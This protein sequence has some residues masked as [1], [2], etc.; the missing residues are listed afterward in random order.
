MFETKY[1]GYARLPDANDVKIIKSKGYKVAVLNTGTLPAEIENN[2][3]F[4]IVCIPKFKI[5]RRDTCYLKSLKHGYFSI[6]NN[7]LTCNSTK[8]RFIITTF[9]DGSSQI[10]TENNLF[11]RIAFEYGGL[12]LFDGTKYNLNERFKFEN[13]NN[14]LFKIKTFHNRYLKTNEDGERVI[15][16]KYAESNEFKFQLSKL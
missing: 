16:D 4:T 2:K 5:T 6:D 14:F 11:A 15:F 13:S 8:T 3:E 9:E 12:I 1:I 7:K 10:K